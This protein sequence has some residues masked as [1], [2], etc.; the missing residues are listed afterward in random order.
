MRSRHE[1][2]P[3]LRFDQEVR[4]STMMSTDFSKCM[5]C[6]MSYDT[7]YMCIYIYHLRKFRL[8]NFR[9]TNEIA[10]SSNR[11]RQVMSSSNRCRQVMSSSSRCRQVMCRQEVGVVK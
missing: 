11:C 4:M 3:G 8:R 2:A 5:Y 1:N 7:V 10:S 9:Y 6:K